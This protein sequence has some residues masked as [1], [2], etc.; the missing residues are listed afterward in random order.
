MGIEKKEEIAEEA[1]AGAATGEATAREKTAIQRAMDGEQEAIADAIKEAV[2][3]AESKA[4]EA[5]SK[6]QEMM[7]E[8]TAV[9][10]KAAEANSAEAAELGKINEAK[11]LATDQ[12]KRG[13]IEIDRIKKELDERGKALQ[14]VHATLAST[15]V[16]VRANADSIVKLQSDVEKTE[17]AN[18]MLQA[19]I[20][21]MKDQFAA[22][23]SKLHSKMK[24][25]DALKGQLA[26]VQEQLAAANKTEVS[27]ARVKEVKEEEANVEASANAADNKGTKAALKML[28]EK[29]AKLKQDTA[30][31]EAAAKKAGTESKSSLW[32]TMLGI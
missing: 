26:M 29:E 22:Q 23:A 8:L 1:K 18:K 17:N 28:K 25:R 6:E 20:K 4:A 3:F 5:E 32:S 21:D 15:S 7:T 30:A 31:E 10:S 27:L 24:L 11:K 16:K 19:Q 12:M 14:E 13:E 9:I 2:E